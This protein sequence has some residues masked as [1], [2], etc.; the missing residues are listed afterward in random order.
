MKYGVT[1]VYDGGLEWVEAYD[2]PLKMNY[3]I[4]GQAHGVR[5]G[6]AHIDMGIFDAVHGLYDHLAD[7]VIDIKKSVHGRHARYELRLTPIDGDGRYGVLLEPLY[8]RAGINSV[9]F[10]VS[11]H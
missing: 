7:L 10:V 5:L 4:M 9:L 8:S 1:L 2:L 3:E 11:G 6:W